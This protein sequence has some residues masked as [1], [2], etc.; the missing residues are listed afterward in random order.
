MY[1]EQSGGTDKS[2]IRLIVLLPAD[3]TSPLP[4]FT[5]EFAPVIAVT[6]SIETVPNP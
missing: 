6:R 5:N 1:D 2:P 3:T 4:Q